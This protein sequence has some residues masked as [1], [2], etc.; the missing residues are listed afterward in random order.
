MDTK[1]PGLK[2]GH[3]IITPAC[4]ANRTV[5][6]AFVEASERIQKLY[7]QYAN[8][9]GNKGVHWHLVLVRE[10]LKDEGRPVPPHGSGP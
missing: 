10:D 6:G 7:E 3:A 2:S 1:I 8:M 5:T 9:D 4:R